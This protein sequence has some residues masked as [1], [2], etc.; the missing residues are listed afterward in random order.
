[1][2]KIKIL[3]V[4]DSVVVRRLVTNVLEGDPE[5]EVVGVAANG[6][7]ALAKISQVH[8][9]LIVLDVEMPEMNGLETLAEIRKQDKNI[10]VIMFSALT[11]LGANSTL[12]ALSLGAT[13]YVTKPSNM[14]SKEAAL[15]NVREQLIP[16]IKVFCRDDR[17]Q[18]SGIIPAVKTE[19]KAITTVPSKSLLLLLKQQ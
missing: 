18:K 19:N 10:P 17:W 5:L 3:V 8:P 6:K 1:M 7:I 12:E 9:D 13:D 4:D 11:E 16:K 2:S 15:Q 14:K